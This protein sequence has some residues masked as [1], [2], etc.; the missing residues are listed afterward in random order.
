[1]NG[2]V[3][4]D[5]YGSIFDATD[6][7]AIV[8]PVNCVGVMGKGLAAKFAIQYPRMVTQ[9]HE[10]CKSKTLD[11][12][13]PQVLWVG[14]E[15]MPHYVINL[16][17]KDHWRNPSRLDWIDR[18]LCGLYQKLAA[19]GIGSVGIP[20]LGSGLGGLPW[21]RVKPLINWHASIHPDVRTVI[22]CPME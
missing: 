12:G 6:L 4:E 13:N 3:V 9:Y 2:G 5:R 14:T 16:A 8:N 15:R 11:I 19:E 18:G 21:L 22:F 1:M 10:A 17:T 20:A 7:A